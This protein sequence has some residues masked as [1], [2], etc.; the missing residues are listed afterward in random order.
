MKKMFIFFVL[1]VLQAVCNYYSFGFASAMVSS[2]KSNIILF[3]FLSIV[4]YIFWLPLGLL[5]HT[6]YGMILEWNYPAMVIVNSFIAVGIIY[7]FSSL[8]HK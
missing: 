2:G 1:A 4:N 7:Y 5:G 3:K 8:F 6:K